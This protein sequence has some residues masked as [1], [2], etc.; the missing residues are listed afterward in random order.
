MK[1]T[2]R[3]V[4]K[5]A[6]VQKVLVFIGFERSRGVSKGVQNAKSIGVHRLYALV[7]KVWDAKVSVLIVFEQKSFQ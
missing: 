3:G 6:R 2:S 4:F 5:A 7:A 1:I